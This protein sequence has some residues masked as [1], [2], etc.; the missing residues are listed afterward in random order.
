VAAAEVRSIPPPWAQRFRTDDVDHLRTL[1]AASSREHSRLPRG[2][3]RLGFE[4]ASLT[5]KTTAAG[6]VRTDLGTLVR[7][8]VS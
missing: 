3:G 5:G 1:I 6:W 4:H 8:A 7:G 2:S